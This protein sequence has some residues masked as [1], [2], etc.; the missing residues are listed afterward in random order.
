MKQRKYMDEQ[1]KPSFSSHSYDSNVEQCDP[2][3]PEDM[4]ED[5]PLDLE[6]IKEI[7]D[8]DEKLM[9][10][11]VKYPEWYSCKSINNVEDILCYTK[12]GYWTSRKQEVLWTIRTKIPS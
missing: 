5:H 11:A 6:K 7:Q 3:L 4:F 9:Q 1:N 12:P 2:N 10:S 8:H